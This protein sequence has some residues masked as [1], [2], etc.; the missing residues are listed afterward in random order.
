M[1]CG[2]HCAAAPLHGPHTQPFTPQ[3]HP[4]PPQ[5]LRGEM[6]FYAHV[7]ADIADIFPTLISS[8][9]YTRTLT[10][11]LARTLTLTLTLTRTLTVTLTLTLTPTLTLTLTRYTDPVPSRA[12][13]LAPKAA[14]SAASTPAGRRS[15]LP[16]PATKPEA[17]GGSTLDPVA[18]AAAAATAAIS[19]LKVAAPAAAPAAASSASGAPDDG[20]SSMTLQRIDGVTFSHLVTNRCLTPG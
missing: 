1:Q 10:L 12:P 11:A 4:H 7:P 15:V 20:I 17:G 16:S 3:A 2:M 13:D 6:F 9:E 5:V 8:S 18:A 19:T 14:A